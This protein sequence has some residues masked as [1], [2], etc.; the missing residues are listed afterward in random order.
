MILNINFPSELKFLDVARMAEIFTNI[1]DF[2][3]SE[4]MI[5]EKIALIGE[6]ILESIKE[7]VGYLK[8]FCVGKTYKELSENYGDGFE[9]SIVNNLRGVIATVKKLQE[10]VNGVAVVES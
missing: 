2:D 5:P 10:F 7:S 8:M 3:T 4:N 6:S 9:D 1:S